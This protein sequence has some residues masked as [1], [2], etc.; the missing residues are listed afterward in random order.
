MRLHLRVL[1]SNQVLD[2]IDDIT[3]RHLQTYQYPLG[4]EQRIR[5]GPLM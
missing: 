1:E 4:T 3:Q 5:N 2:C